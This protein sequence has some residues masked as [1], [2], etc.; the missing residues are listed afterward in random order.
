MIEVNGIDHINISVKNID[1]S[2]EFYKNTFDFDLKE[3]G[4]NSSGRRYAIAGKSS[5]IL[6]VFNETSEALGSGRINHIGINIADFDKML[7]SVKELGLE[8]VDYGGDENKVTHYPNSRSLYIL[9]PDG[10]EIELTSN[11][12]GGL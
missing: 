6:F 11:F 5:K 9:D 12:G 1:R 8:V 7:S 10:N 4:V 3:G 2:L